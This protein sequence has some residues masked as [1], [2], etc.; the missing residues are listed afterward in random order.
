MINSNA[1]QNGA[2]TAYVYKD[3]RG[4]KKE[5]KYYSHYHRAYASKKQRIK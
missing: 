5:R 2:L 3:S 4:K 1:K